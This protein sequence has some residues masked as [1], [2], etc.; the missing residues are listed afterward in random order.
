MTDR[1]PLG[2]EAE[3]LAR[4]RAASRRRRTSTAGPARRR[5]VRTGRTATPSGP[6]PDARA[7]QRLG[8]VWRALADGRGWTNEVAVWSLANRWEAIVGPQVAAH[9]AVVSFD[10]RPASAGDPADRATADPGPAA[11]RGRQQALLPDPAPAPADHPPGTGGTLQLRAD[12]GAWQQQ[13]VWNLAHLQ[14]RLDEELGAGVVGRIVV[15]GPTV[16]RPNYGP[17]RA[18]R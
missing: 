6:G 2:A 12:S 10:P 14:R 3:A 8:D 13:M 5:A 15:L 16:R 7:P 1:E 17:R 9:V 18:T 4:Y 11:G